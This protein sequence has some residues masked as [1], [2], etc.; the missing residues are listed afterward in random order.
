LSYF[1]E[2]AWP[3]AA[4]AA[5]S[6]RRRGLDRRGLGRRLGDDVGGGR[7]DGRRVGRLGVS[8]AGDQHG[9]EREEALLHGRHT[10]CEAAAGM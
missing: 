6:G 7:I 2:I 9:D 1:A 3:S 10:R 4:G 8:Q 5:G